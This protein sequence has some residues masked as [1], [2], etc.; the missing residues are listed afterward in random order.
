MA[1]ENQAC[2]IWEMRILKYDGVTVGVAGFCK[3]K[4]CVNAD[5]QDIQYWS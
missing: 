3:Q 4:G 2:S 1:E 5:W